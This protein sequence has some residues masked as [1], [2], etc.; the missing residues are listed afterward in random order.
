MLNVIL[1]VRII[2]CTKLLHKF[3]IPLARNPSTNKSTVVPR[4]TKRK[5]KDEDI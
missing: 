3:I 2:M 4:D 1:N 5:T